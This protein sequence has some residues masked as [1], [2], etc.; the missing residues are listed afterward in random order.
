MHDLIAPVV[1]LQLVI[2][3]IFYDRHLDTVVK[4]LVRGV[5]GDVVALA[6]NLERTTDPGERARLIED[7]PLRA[8]LA[9]SGR[10][11]VE[12]GFHLGRSVARLAG[13]LLALPTVGRVTA[14]E[15][16]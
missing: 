11:T 1:I 15:A 12:D 14:P 9:A 6:D 16:H 7:A 2:G 4:R 13:L 5:V 10:A 3:A 8:R